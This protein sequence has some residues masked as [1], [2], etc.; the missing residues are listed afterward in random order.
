MEIYVVSTHKNCLN[1]ALLMSTHNIC[2]RKDIRKIF[3]WIFLLSGAMQNA[4]CV[5]I[6]EQTLL[7]AHDSVQLQ[8]V[9]VDYVTS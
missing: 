1:E 8:L 6:S 4:L 7:S 3:I 9:R 5:G 2:F